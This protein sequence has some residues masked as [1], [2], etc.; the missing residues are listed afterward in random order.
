MI[1]VFNELVSEAIDVLD[2]DFVMP[3][4]EIR[5]GNA[6]SELPEPEVVAQ[7]LISTLFQH[8]NFHVRRVAVQ[9]WR[10]IAVP[11]VRGLREALLQALEDPESWVRYDAAWAIREIGYRDEETLNFLSVV[12]DGAIYPDD[13]AELEV[14]L[15]NS[16]N[17]AR[18]EAA[19][20]IYEFNKDAV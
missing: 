13:E 19:Q 6:F 8:H 2:A 18:L 11:N 3:I 4:D 9:A 7:E 12:A 16:E 15:S 17:R 1:S 10:R 20:A 5:L 14:D